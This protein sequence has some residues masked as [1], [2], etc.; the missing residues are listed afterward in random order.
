[1]PF[2]PISAGVAAGGM[3]LD[4]LKS[5]QARQDSQRATQNAMIQ[6]IQGKGDTL[7]QAGA[8][9][10]DQFGN[11]TYYDPTQGRWVT[12]LTPTQQRIIDEGQARQ[13]RAQIRGTQASQD[14]DT[15]R[16][17]YLYRQPKTE[18]QSYDEIVRLLN[19]AQGTEAQRENALMNRFRMRTEGNIPRLEEAAGPS[20]AQTLAETMLKARQAALD[21]SLKRTAGHASQYLPA[22]KQFEE[23]ANYMAPIDP[24]GSGI[25]G[26]Q[27]SG[28]QDMLKYGTDYDKL[29]A[30][31]AGSGARNAAAG[32]SG[33]PKSSDFL[34]LAKM[35]MPGQDKTGG[36][37]GGTRGARASTSG[38]DGGV[39][40]DNRFN[41]GLFGKGSG[42][43]PYAGEASARGLL[44]EP[45]RFDPAGGG[46][47][48]PNQI[49]SFDPRFGDTFTYSR[50]P[51]PDYG[52]LGVGFGSGN[53]ASFA[54]G[55]YYNPWQ[56]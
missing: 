32:S 14:Y 21:E 45:G 44:G 30:T 52:D 10:F 8:L 50:P 48:D 2:D 41:Y 35:L 16:A 7:R 33:G 1:M 4:F 6:A 5:Q 29:L 47:N 37:T 39:K 26:M 22:L 17:Q 56:F 34:N 31:I 15:L 24:T 54:P 20:G 51:I 13:R 25:I 42:A 9:R 49:T 11:A 18:A 23:T 28:I 12:S 38:D 55:D 3:I 27:Q 36:T 40:L 46:F 53:A 43:Y 19:Q